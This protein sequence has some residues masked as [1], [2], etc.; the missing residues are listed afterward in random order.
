MGNLLGIL[1]D[2]KIQCPFM[3]SDVSLG[4]CFTPEPSAPARHTLR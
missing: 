2:Y 3:I 1:R 4:L